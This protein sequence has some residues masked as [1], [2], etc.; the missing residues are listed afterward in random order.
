MTN[1]TRYLDTTITNLWSRKALV[2]ATWVTSSDYAKNPIPAAPL[3]H[4]AL[5]TKEL[6]GNETITSG[7]TVYVS[8][9]L[10]VTFSWL[11]DTLV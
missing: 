6:Q 5:V 11:T 10:L 3:Y 2:D 8:Y 4:Q 1:V 7:V 9:G